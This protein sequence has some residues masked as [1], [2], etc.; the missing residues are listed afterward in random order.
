[1]PRR[2]KPARAAAPRPV[3]E[4]PEKKTQVDTSPPAQAQTAMRP[5]APDAR[6]DEPTPES[7]PGVTF[8][9]AAAIADPE[10]HAWWH[11]NKGV[12]LKIS[13]HVVCNARGVCGTLEGTPIQCRRYVDALSKELD[14]EVPASALPNPQPMLTVI[15]TTDE[16]AE[17]LEN[18]DLEPPDY[19]ALVEDWRPP[20]FFPSKLVVD[21]GPLRLDEGS[22]E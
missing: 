16:A 2:K 19:D 10:A 3:A 18:A 6:I 7:K 12:A 11:R 15:P 9:A 20:L 14:V 1:M 5:S 22:S 13:G 8:R 21:V 4:A 17:L